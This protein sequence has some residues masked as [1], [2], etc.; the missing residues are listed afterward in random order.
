MITYGS[1]IVTDNSGF[2]LQNSIGTSLPA[3]VLRFKFDEPWNPADQF[4]NYTWVC[5]DMYNGVWDCVGIS[6]NVDG[7]FQSLGNSYVKFMVIDGNLDGVTSMDRIFM[8]VRD[9]MTYACIPNIPDVTSMTN[10]FMDTGV[11]YLYMGGL[12]SLTSM[13]SLINN[14]TVPG[15]TLVLEGTSSLTSIENA[16]QY[17]N[18]GSFY[19]SDTS[20]LVNIDAA[21]AGCGYLTVIPTIDVTNVTSMSETFQNCINVNSGITD[22]YNRASTKEIPVIYHSG[23]F[24]HCGENSPTGSIELAQIP[25]D[26]K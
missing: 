21:W 10:A 25:S 11:S 23:T 15:G 2:W 6:G 3:G 18:F 12:E 19:I 26:W 14:S 16:F 8:D 7:Y 24:L 13:T 22:L 20:N 5:V 1:D 4:P 9:K 17:S